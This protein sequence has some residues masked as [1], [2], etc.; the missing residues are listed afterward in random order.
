L[1]KAWEDSGQQTTPATLSGSPTVRGTK[2]RG[3]P[4]DKEK[5]DR[6]VEKSQWA[7][8]VYRNVKTLSSLI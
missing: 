6:T 7:R 1:A 4:T 3:Y 8:H 2:W 5:G